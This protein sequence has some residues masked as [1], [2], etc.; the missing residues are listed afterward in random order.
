VKVQR[1]VSFGEGFVILS[2]FAS[3]ALPHLIL[4]YFT[5]KD[6]SVAHV[7]MPSMLASVSI[8]FI[9]VLLWNSVQ[10]KKSKKNVI[11]A[12]QIFC[13][14]WCLLVLVILY[15][16]TCL[17]QKGYPVE[18][19]YIPVAVVSVLALIPMLVLFDY[20]Q[21]K[22]KVKMRS[23]GILKGEDENERD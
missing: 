7:Y 5:I 16:L 6:L 21:R 10:R 8:W 3:L 23:Q 12:Q 17:E 19:L 15:I 2:F 20:S 18:H 1:N 22:K 13:I 9:G 4:I 11:K 14:S